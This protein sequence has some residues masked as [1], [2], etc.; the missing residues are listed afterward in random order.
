MFDERADLVAGAVRAYRSWRVDEHGLISAYIAARWFSPAMAAQCLRTRRLGGVADADTD[1]AA[2]DPSCRCGIYAWYQPG[3][4]EAVAGQVFGVVEL[5][6]RMLLGA[7]GLRAEKA[8]VLAVSLVPGRGRRDVDRQRL[9]RWCT[10]NDVELLDDPAAVAERFPPEDVQELIGMPVVK[11]PITPETF[12]IP[13]DLAWNVVLLGRDT[14]QARLWIAGHEA[15][16]QL[17]VFSARKRGQH[18]RR[19]R[20]SDRLV[21]YWLPGAVTVLL[22]WSTGWWAALAYVGA[23]AAAAIVA[24][25]IVRRRSR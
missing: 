10:A 1:H 9:Q 12:Q 2:P 25:E 3:D 21:R 23:Y 17:Q 6:G 24:T 20:W 4:T 16:S 14:Q 11:A 15:L 7:R 22:G 8:R 5:T 13:V 18:A 19:V